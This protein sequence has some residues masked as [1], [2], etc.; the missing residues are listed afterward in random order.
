[1][2]KYALNSIKLGSKQQDGNKVL[3]SKHLP[4][5]PVPDR[6]A[7]RGAATEDRPVPEEGEFSTE[8]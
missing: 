6:V 1:M 2:A 3:T 5:E 4:C 7:N 8:P